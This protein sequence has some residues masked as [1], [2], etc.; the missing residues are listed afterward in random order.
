MASR[1]SS[2]YFGEKYDEAPDNFTFRLLI[3][4]RSYSVQAP[5]NVS[6]VDHTIRDGRCTVEGRAAVGI[7]EVEEGCP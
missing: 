5:I 3:I 2:Y 1:A 7:Q 4:L 6:N